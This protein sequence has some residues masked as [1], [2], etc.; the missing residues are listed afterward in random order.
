M[1]VQTCNLQTDSTGNVQAGARAVEAT[2]GVALPLKD[3]EGRVKAVLGIAFEKEREFSQDELNSADAGCQGPFFKLHMNPQL[4]QSSLLHVI[5]CHSSESA[6]KW[7]DQVYSNIERTFDPNHFTAA[8]SGVRR[9]LGTKKI[10]FHSED[11]GFPFD[12]DM[13]Y[14]ST[15]QPWMNWDEPVYCYEQRRLSAIRRTQIPFY[16]RYL[17]AW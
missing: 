5:R 9:R 3:Q 13:K 2:A 10:M 14:H 7:F 15:M 1:P 6:R 17:S 11:E 12:P 16:W 8:Y 4:I